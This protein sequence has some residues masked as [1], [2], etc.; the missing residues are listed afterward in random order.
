[1]RV[2]KRL[3]DDAAPGTA[4]ARATGPVIQ[5][6]PSGPPASTVGRG[7]VVSIDSPGLSVTARPPRRRLTRSR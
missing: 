3:G 1:M 2:R 7:A 4:P 5:R 6:G